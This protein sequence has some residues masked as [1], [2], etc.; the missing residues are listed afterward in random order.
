M[1]LHCASFFSGI[2]GMDIAF[3]NAGFEIIYANENDSNAIKTYEKNISNKVDS[4]NFYD[5][6]INEIPDFHILL[7]SLPFKFNTNDYNLVNKFLNI[8]N[9][10]NPKVI[11]IETSKKIMNTENKVNYFYIM[12]KLEEL[13]YKVVQRNLDIKLHGNIPQNKEKTYVLAFLNHVQ[14][15]KF[16]FPEP[17]LLSKNLYD[18]IDFEEKKDDK[19]YYNKDKFIHYK[20]LTKMIVKENCIYTWSR[21]T[22]RE[23]ANGVCSTLPNNMGV[24][25]HTVPLIKAHDGIRKLTPKECSL[26][27]GFPLEFILSDEVSDTQLYKQIG[28]SSSVCIIN[29]IASNLKETFSEN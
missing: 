9:I 16:E 11:F 21:N 20:E 8:I 29:K 2:G 10:K 3:K 27:Q 23:M 13:G 26:L 1:K 12:N 24:G 4:R 5:I 6:S 22:V 19:Y 15:K 14:C 25:G 28:I 17:M 7:A 18:Y